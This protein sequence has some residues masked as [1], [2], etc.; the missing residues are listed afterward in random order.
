MALH[1]KRL[2]PQKHFVNKIV[3]SAIAGLIILTISLFIG[4]LGYHHY[5]NLGWVDSLYNASMILTGMGP[6]DKAIND[7]GKLFASFYAIYSGV[8]F[9]TSVAIIISPVVHRFLHKFRI[10]VE[11]D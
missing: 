10:D 1:V 11:G 3:R 8:T 7:G 9:L 2:P 4:M 6:V 5:F